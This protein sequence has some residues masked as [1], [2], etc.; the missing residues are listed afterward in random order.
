M[1]ADPKQAKAIFLEAV[2]KHTP[3]QWLA[4][5]DQACAGQPELRRHV[6][7][8]LKA[9]RDVGTALHQDGTDSLAPAG[10][11]TEGPGTMLG[12]Y[13]L[14]EQIGEGGFGVVF[15]AEQQQ[16]VRRKVA[17]KD[18]KPGMDSKQVIARFEAE[19]QA[20]ALMDHANIARVLDGGE[21]ATGRPFFVMDL[22]KGVPITHYCDQNQLTPRQRLELFV[23]V[24]QAVQHAHQ[25]GIIHRDVKPS[26]VLISRHDGT[27]VVKVIDFGI[28]K[29]LGQQLTDKTLFTNFAQMIGTPLYMSP[30]QAGMSDLDVDTRS[31]IYSLGVL[32]YELL[33]GTTPFD[34]K[35]FKEV[36]FDEMRRIIR[37]EE[38]PKPSTRISTLGQ[39]ATTVSTNRKSDPRQL[40]RLFRGEL[41]WIVMKAL[42]KDR[43]RRYET[44]SAFAA[45]VQRYLHDEPVHACPPSAWYR[46]GKFARRNRAALLALAAALTLLVVVGAGIWSWQ[47][48]ETLRRAENEFHSELTR[49]NVKSWLEQL[50]ELHR[51][52]L[53][54]QAE[55]LLDQADQQLGPDGDGPLRER[56]AQARRDTAF[57]KRLDE[58][59]LETSVM[60]EGKL[61]TA[62]ASAKYLDAFLKHELDILQGE[63][64]DLAKRLNA[65]PVRD[66]LLAALDDWAMLEGAD[67]K[68]ILAVTAE[69]TG[70]EWRRR[71]PHAWDDG[72]KLAEFFDAVP[73]SQ[74]TPAIIHGVGSRLYDL[75]EDGVSRLDEGL[76]QYPADFWLHF[77]LG[78]MGGKK[79]VDARIGANR[80]AL[81]LRPGTPAVL[82]NLGAALHDK[83]EYDAAIAAYLEAD[84]LDSNNAR[85]HY[86]IGQAL[87]HKREYAAVAARFQEAIRLDPKLSWPHRGL[88]DVLLA[89]K[90]YD[91]AVAEYRKAMR[92]DPKDAGPHRGLG[93]VLLARKKYE[94]AIAEFK[95]AI[96]LNPKFALPHNNLGTVLWDKKEYQAA[97]AE[98]KEAIR[99]DP[100]DAGPHINLGKVLTDKKEYE[101]AIAE[102]KE[103]I[104]LDPQEPWAHINMSYA[105]LEKNEHEAAIA[106]LKEAIRLDPQEPQAHNNMGAALHD[107]KKYEAAIAA[108]NEAIRLDPNFAL[109]HYGLGRVLLAKKEYEAAIAAY[110]E[111][112][113]L[114]PKLVKAYASLGETLFK[115]KRPDLA[116]TVY[117]KAVEVAPKDPL[118][119]FNLGVSFEVQQR[120][121]EA[122]AAYQ[123][124]VNLDENLVMARH[125]LGKMLGVQLRF[126][127]AIDALNKAIAIDPKDAALRRDLGI[128]YYNQGNYLRERQ[129]FD[130]AIAAYQKA[131]AI[132][133]RNA[134]AYVNLGATLHVRKRLEEA[135]AACE[136]AI[137]IDPK[138]ANA[139]YNLGLML[140]DQKRPE[141]AL[142]AFQTAIQIEPNHTDARRGLGDC[143]RLLALEDKLLDVLSGRKQPADTAERLALAQ[144]CQEDKKRHAAAARFYAEAFAA[145]PK[146]LSN[147]PSDLR[148]NAA[149]AAALA[150]CGQGK[151]AA[152]LDNQE[153]ARLRQQALEW[154]RADLA[155]YR[156]LVDRATVKDRAL[157]AKAMR[158]WLA[159]AD[160]AGLRGLSALTNLSEAERLAW[161]ELWGQVADTLARAQAQ[162]TPEKKTNKK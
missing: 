162:V 110:N 10:A 149:C 65:S 50:P 144:L 41:D 107:K 103:A 100:Y 51:R 39:A 72:K 109:A 6:E 15:M 131:V 79:R 32:L 14:L 34:Q 54:K 70:L 134:D 101:A 47:H 64:A 13:K 49:R 31:D 46:F 3:D 157:V 69:A 17:L 37:E 127:E 78:T 18:L 113:R 43:N 53:W 99:L 12:P 120:P 73:R 42:E 52:A 114:D 147:Q 90:Q 74:R 155:C 151:D 150:G 22:V 48:Q 160:F 119:H 118:A 28:A 116:M 4:F 23:Q 156:K 145:E 140:I 133:P 94:A 40:S 38:P 87:Q 152:K 97:I 68:R 128:T 5:L 122:L 153:R 11:A 81:A 20:L 16:P 2:E 80:A 83:K 25:K 19:R 76:R 89:K 136:K 154:L 104:R 66:Y 8:L 138:I 139:Y 142:K 44:V 36:G 24:C 67:L 82:M 26:N 55:T 86:N 75:G 30:E 105:L 108:Y 33:T 29:A 115:Q 141:K 126:E 130:Q 161:Q 21:T 63:L 102:L 148:Y 158:H 124:A 56:L 84:R 146:L 85:F 132:D 57:I 62:G 117:Q 95:E 125:G 129:Q 1:N 60:V 135:I 45:D 71:L 123:Q 61:N 91:A 96:R 9:H 77:A 137:H 112:I 143:E 98:F 7:V 27:P 92:L 121:K 111:A 59:R 35:R 159:D 58:V 88:G 93:S 106:E